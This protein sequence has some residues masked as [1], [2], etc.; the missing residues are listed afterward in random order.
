MG[1]TFVL[2]ILW[3]CFEGIKAVVYYILDRV[4]EVMLD[5]RLPCNWIKPPLP[6]WKWKLPSYRGM[7]LSVHTLT[8]WD[9]IFAGIVTAS[10][11]VFVFWALRGSGS[12]IKRKSSP[13]ANFI[14]DLKFIGLGIALAALWYG[15]RSL[16]TVCH[17]PLAECYLIPTPVL[18]MWWRLFPVPLGL[19]KIGGAI[20]SLGRIVARKISR[21]P[22]HVKQR[23]E[24]TS[25]LVRDLAKEE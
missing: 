13:K 9:W 18:G 24:D 20:L 12:I 17:V 8:A 23:M 16:L 6:I 2:M 22:L 15:I 19:F 5:W 21:I 11:G 14:T 25:S 4:R 10:W 7:Q 1:T 3:K